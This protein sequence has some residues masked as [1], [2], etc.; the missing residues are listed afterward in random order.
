MGNGLGPKFSP[1]FSTKSANN[2]LSGAKTNGA[3]R[4]NGGNL[5][6]VTLAEVPDDGKSWNAN[7]GTL[8]WVSFLREILECKLRYPDDGKSWNAS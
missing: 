2:P 4:P 6:E 3:C 5:A 1:K 7:L 8:A